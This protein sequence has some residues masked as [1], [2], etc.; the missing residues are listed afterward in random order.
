MAGHVVAAGSNRVRANPRGRGGGRAR[1]GTGPSVTGSLQLYV[2]VNF[3]KNKE[4]RRSATIFRRSRDSTTFLIHES[5]QF[6]F[7]CS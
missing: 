5:V 2:K 3:Y 7:V 4:N 1:G 6:F